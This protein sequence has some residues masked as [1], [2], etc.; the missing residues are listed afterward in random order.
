M[1]YTKNMSLGDSLAEIH[2]FRP[3]L[4]EAKTKTDKPTD[5]VLLIVRQ[6]NVLIFQIKLPYV[7]IMH[8]VV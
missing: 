7:I 8:T 4:E 3:T 1:K 5:N 2:E 6:R